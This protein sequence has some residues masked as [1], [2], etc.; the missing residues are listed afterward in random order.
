MP[1][2]VS[3]VP[4]LVEK[5]WTGKNGDKI[6]TCHGLIVENDKVKVS[7][8]YVM[9]GSLIKK[10]GDCWKPSEGANEVVPSIELVYEVE[11]E[12]IHDRKV[13]LVDITSGTPYSLV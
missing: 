13:R 3:F 9:G 1:Q 5:E 8:V 2:A 4:V 12:G 6:V 10:L 11:G 7:K